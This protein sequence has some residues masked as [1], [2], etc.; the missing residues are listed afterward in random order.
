MII[1]LRTYLHRIPAIVRLLYP[2]VSWNED[3]NDRVLYLTFDDGPTPTVTDFVLDQLDKYRSKATFF[4]IGKNIDR[5][6]EIFKKI[7]KK[8]HSFGNHSH[9]HINGWNSSQESYVNDVKK[10]EAAILKIA[11]TS[12]RLFRPPYGKIK[13][14]QVTELKNSY[15]IVLWNYLI[16][17]FDHNLSA[18][19]CLEKAKKGVKNSDIIVF[20]DNEKSFE[21]LKFV[22]PK[23]LEHFSAR[24]FE[25]RAL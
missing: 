7:L 23:F 16:G 24:G 20:H 22:L 17:D 2:E 11:S 13:L 1:K 3:C 12:K 5:Y 14:S 9:K 6:P 10:C 25:F 4:C 18:K 21:S 19:K 15:K 8:G